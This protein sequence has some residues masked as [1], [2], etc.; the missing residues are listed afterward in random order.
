MKTYLVRI[1]RKSI[2]ANKDAGQTSVNELI[3]TE[4]HIKM[5]GSH[6]SLE[7]F[8]NRIKMLGMFTSISSKENI[9]EAADYL[10]CGQS[11]E[12]GEILERLG[13]KYKKQLSYQLQN[14][15]QQIDFLTPIAP[16]DYE[17][18]KTKV[19]CRHCKAKFTH[20]KLRDY[21]DWDDDGYYIGRSMVCPECDREDVCKLEF[22]D[23][24]RIML[25]KAGLPKLVTGSGDRL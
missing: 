5:K 25:S 2:K 1:D 21:D 22:E 10:L 14:H 19:Q 20:D 3:S 13:K 6:E 23:F 18:R 11:D 4:V 24:E 8:N 17:Y 16:Y 9:I 12:V 7:K 15:Y